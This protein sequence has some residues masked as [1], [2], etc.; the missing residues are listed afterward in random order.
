[1]EHRIV[2]QNAHMSWQFLVHQLF[3]RRMVRVTEWYAK[4][5]VSSYLVEDGVI[6]VPSV[7]EFA[8][9]YPIGLCE[10]AACSA[11]WLPDQNDRMYWDEEQLMIVCEN[12]NQN[13]NNTHT[14]MMVCMDTALIRGDP[15]VHIHMEEHVDT[16]S[17]LNA[18]HTFARTFANELGM[19]YFGGKDTIQLYHDML[20]RR[21]VRRW[22]RMIGKRIERR[23]TCV[24]ENK[25]GLGYETC[26]ALAKTALGQP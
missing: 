2:A 10:C 5:Y 26:Q 1:M 23:L 6:L 14:V 20:G 8:S 19:H 3:Q 11:L 22:R 7:Y 12:C 24:F 13:R 21:T 25:L 9:L 18:G 15:T 4:V 16:I 17:A